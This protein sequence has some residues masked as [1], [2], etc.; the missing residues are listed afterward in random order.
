MRA[1]PQTERAGAWIWDSRPC[2]QRL[3]APVLI[4][5]R[6]SAHL[7][8]VAFLWSPAWGS[9][10]PRVRVRRAPRSPAP[11]RELRSENQTFFLPQSHE[12]PGRRAG[13]A[14]GTAG[15]SRRVKEDSA[16]ISKV[17]PGGGAEQ[18]PEPLEADLAQRCLFPAR[19]L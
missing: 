4:F 16:Q 11:W 15:G 3:S 17:C 18:G 5:A 19:Q 10:L 8:Q 2:C 12:Q 6:P 13:P 1:E 7:D 9:S 14:W